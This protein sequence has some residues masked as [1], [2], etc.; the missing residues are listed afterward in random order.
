MI[1][2]PKILFA[3]C[4]LFL[5]TSASAIDFD[6]EI[7][8]LLK[9]NCVSC[10]GEDES[11]GGLRLDRG[12]AT[13]GRTDSGKP[14]IVP[15][16]PDASELIRRVTSSDEA[17]VMPPEGERLSAQ[18]IELLRRWIEQG[19]NGLR[20]G[21]VPDGDEVS[22]DH[23]AFRPIENP[24]PPAVREPSWPRG[25]I[26][27]FLQHRREAAGMDVGEDARP[28][29]VIRRATYGLTGLPPTLQEVDAFEER[30]RAVGMGEALSHLV[31]ELLHRPAYGERW[32][33]HWMDWVR[34]ADTA[35]DNSDYP[36]PQAYLYR[37][38]I[39]DALNADIPY[40]Q[41]LVEQI[42]GDLLPAESLE[43]RNR[44][45]I[46]TGY[47][48][49]ARR[50]GSLVE[51]YPWHL[52]IEDTIDNVGRTMMGVT[53]ACARCHDHKFDPFS[54]RDYYGLYGI[55]ASTKYPFPGIE[56]FK[57]QRDFVSLLDRSETES[58]LRDSKP[59]TDQLVA[60]LESLLERCRKKSIDNAMREKGSSLDEQRKRRGQLD[61]M[62]IKARRAGEKLAEHLRTVPAIPTAYAVAE[63]TPVNARL[64]I[65]GE[66]TRPG[67][68]VER[69][70]PLILGAWELDQE[71]AEKTSGRLQLAR[72]ITHRDNPLTARVIVNRVWERHFGSG[73]VPSTSDFG[74]R[75]QKPTHPDL[76]DWLATDFVRNGWSLKH[77][78]RRIMAS[79]AYV[80]S[81]RSVAEN[82]RID[83][84]NHLYWRFDRRRLD[85]ESIRDTLMQIAG[86]LDATPQT[87]P[88]PFPNRDKW[89][90]TQH[91]PF[92]ADYA[93]SK[94]SV[95]LMT[96]RLT[97]KPYFQTFDGPDP[98]VCTSRRDESVTALQA[99]FF[100]NDEFLHEQADRFA[101][102]I[103]VS[104][105][106]GRATSPLR[107]PVDPLSSPK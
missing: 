86:T 57:A 70:F 12:H 69:R 50:F 43:E 55:F 48:A 105:G 71:V 73:I 106:N 36:I 87:A 40:D 5:A 77:L 22:S 58:R 64:Q 61:A 63:A 52:T 95:Y 59:T 1:R 41:F 74:T 29:A 49:M 62:L 3:V 94:R 68:E 85:A 26:D 18:S 33:R 37:N 35:G 56:L 76:L 23:W 103:H 8:P 54:T 83:P 9:Q 75:G 65:K 21:S 107:L 15:G 2:V 45:T 34:Y 104:D 67:A 13:S 30:V 14:A 25:P 96:K 97:A 10:H 16:R 66:P 78:H 17:D 27:Q 51:R 7:A 92:K 81:S 89:S 100:A 32:G 82:R 98:N 11:N 46:A 44:Q 19:A 79:H 99:L 6:S 101:R 31:D 38:Y 93:S 42:A 4:H 60:E 88:H 90:F 53:I 28:V 84:D 80:L 39:I 24:V 20:D 91:H 102:R 47:L 72:W